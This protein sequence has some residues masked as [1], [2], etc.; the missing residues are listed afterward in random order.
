LRRGGRQRRIDDRAAEIQSALRAEQ[1]AAPAA[2]SRAMGASVTAS[3]AVIASMVASIDTLAEELAAAF[4]Q[5]PDAKVV[6]SLPG[7]GTILG[8]RV[9]G[10]FGDEPNRYCTAKSQQ[11]LCRHVA[12]HPG[13]GHQAGGL[14]PL[15]T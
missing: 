13:V 7:L 9:L 8:A 10:E 15:R 4:E 11:E 3:V 5:H 1:L 12:H 6:L 14:G 2:V